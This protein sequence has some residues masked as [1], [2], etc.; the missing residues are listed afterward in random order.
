MRLVCT[1]YA[2]RVHVCLLL[3][4]HDLSDMLIATSIDFGFSTRAWVPQTDALCNPHA[5]ARGCGSVYWEAM[6]VHSWRIHSDTQPRPQ[7]LPTNPSKVYGPRRVD[8][9][10]A[11]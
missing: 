9:Y 5:S 6:P 11:F 1:S 10:G 3:I 4:V 2:S 8:N 7:P